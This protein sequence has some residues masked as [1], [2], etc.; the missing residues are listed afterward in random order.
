VH[1]LLESVLGHGHN[2]PPIVSPSNAHR[3][4]QR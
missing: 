2:R 3:H 4:H 1:F